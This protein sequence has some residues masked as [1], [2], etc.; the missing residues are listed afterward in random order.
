MLNGKTNCTL[1][2]RLLQGPETR[3]YQVPL[4]SE[5]TSKQQGSG[6]RRCERR[7]SEG[8]L[9]SRLERPRCGASPQR[10]DV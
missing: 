7:D 4:P 3:L 2:K 1:R 9:G 10:Y 6:W 8:M 5:W